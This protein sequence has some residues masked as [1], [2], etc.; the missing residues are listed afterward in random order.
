MGDTYMIHVS[1]EIGVVVEVEANS[2]HEAEQA[3][4][5]WFD[6]HITLDALDDLET[7]TEMYD[8][9]VEPDFRIK[10]DA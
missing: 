2:R 5:D 8:G 7:L 1:R 4:I 6:N 3:A 9:S 10:A